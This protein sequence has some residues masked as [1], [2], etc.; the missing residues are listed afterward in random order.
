MDYSLNLA[1]FYTNQQISEYLVRQLDSATPQNVL[2]IGCGESSL[3]FAAG[4]RWK[5]ATLYGFDIDPNNID[6][7]HKNL[8]LLS[9]DGLYPDLKNRILDVCGDVEICVSNPPYLSVDYN[10]KARRI[11][12]QVGLDQV[13]GAD[14]RKIP[15]ELVFLAQNFSVLKKGGEIGVI[16]PAGLISGVRW[17][18]FRE[19]LLSEYSIKSC[20]QLPNN[21][22]KRAEASTFAVCLKK[23]ASRSQNVTL[24][25]FDSRSSYLASNEDAV[26]RMDYE[27]Y[28]GSSPMKFPKGK[29]GVDSIFRG[30]KTNSELRATGREYIHTTDLANGYSEIVSKVFKVPAGV[31]YAEEGDILISRVGS[32]CMG[33]IAYLKKGRVP[34]SDCIFVVRGMKGSDSWSSLCK[35]NLDELLKIS[36]LGVGARYLT[37]GIMKEIFYVR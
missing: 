2:D 8:N 11:L 9:G 26:Q 1:Q 6:K 21:A 33:R 19:F 17:R 12:S 36:A 7:Q 34:I 3:L 35:S 15:S 20:V 37:L 18:P 24:M 25:G 27:F 10:S 29:I 32:R 4:K 16:L 13:I 22:F 5:N 28:S 30:N 14:T 23:L 31:K